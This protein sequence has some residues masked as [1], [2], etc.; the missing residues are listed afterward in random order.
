MTGPPLASPVLARTLRSPAAIFVALAAVL[1]TIVGLSAAHLP[2]TAVEVE[3][4]PETPAWAAAWSHWDSGWYRAIADEGY[5]YAGPGAQSSVAFFPAYPALMAVLG[6]VVGDLL[7]AGVLIT[8]ACGLG[9]SLLF[10]H[11]CRARLGGRA[12]WT[13]GATLA[14]YPFAYFL[15]GAVY[16]DA[17]FLVGA[18]GAFILAERGSLWLAGLAGAVATAARPVGGAVV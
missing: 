17:L 14:A 11:W 16:A 18:L 4:F 8:F 9:V 10:H 6:R 1:F 2:G 7:V 13:A 5:T 15:T 3:R 12:A